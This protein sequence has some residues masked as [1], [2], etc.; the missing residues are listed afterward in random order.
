MLRRCIVKFSS[1]LSRNLR[2]GHVL[3]SVADG[4]MAGDTVHVKLADK[5][6]STNGND[7]KRRGR[8]S[9]VI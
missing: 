7:G 2:Q 9:I 3:I 5:Q 1:V 4:G 8:V 6:S